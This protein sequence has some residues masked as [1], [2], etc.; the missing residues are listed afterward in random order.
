MY[1]QTYWAIGADASGPSGIVGFTQPTGFQDQRPGQ[2]PFAYAQGPRRRPWGNPVPFQPR[3]DSPFQPALP[4]RNPHNPHSPHNPHNTPFRFPSADRP[5]QPNPWAG[6][7]DSTGGFQESGKGIEYENPQDASG[8]AGQQPYPGQTLTNPTG[9]QQ[10]NTGGQFNNPALQPRPQPNDRAI[11]EDPQDAMDLSRNTGTH[12]QPGQSNTYPTGLQQPNNGGQFNNPSIQPRP[13]A[14]APDSHFQTFDTPHSTL[15][16]RPSPEA[17][18][19]NP[20]ETG[21]NFQSSDNT[22]N[23]GQTGLQQSAVVQQAGSSIQPRPS[24]LPDNRHTS[25]NPIQQGFGPSSSVETQLANTH[26]IQPIPHVYE[27]AGLQQSNAEQGG[28]TIRPTPATDSNI[29]DT[30]SS[31]FNTHSYMSPN[32]TEQGIVQGSKNPESIGERNLFETSPQCKAGM[33]VRG[34]RCRQKA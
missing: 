17:T 24:V 14:N 33:E 6:S 3:Q 22:E 29:D 12:P 1:G 4:S 16:P 13:Q 26:R 25:G 34:G 20:T 11:L 7:S 9:F 2:P 10:P 21:F 32:L 31:I 28:I 8:N 23:S 19:G 15:Q 27:D 30:I 18:S 5:L